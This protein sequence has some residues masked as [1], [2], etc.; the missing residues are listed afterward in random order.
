MQRCT[1]RPVGVT[2]CRRQFFGIQT[3][4]PRVGVEALPVSRIDCPRHDLNLLVVI[5][6]G[7]KRHR[8]VRQAL[9]LN[10]LRITRESGSVGCNLGPKRDADEPIEGAGEKQPLHECSLG[11]NDTGMHGKR[12]SSRHASRTRRQRRGSGEFLKAVWIDFIRSWLKRRVQNRY[13]PP[14]D[15]SRHVEGA[16]SCAESGIFH[17]PR[18]GCI[19][20]RAVGPFDPG[21]Y[22][23]LVGPGRDGAA[24][25]REFFRPAHRVPRLP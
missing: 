18:V 5:I 6:L 17:D 22:D 16:V 20:S 8:R 19:A 21:E 13:E 11:K 14:L 10:G 3:E 2:T 12:A 1:G 25:V 24:E 4:F 23:G 15:H 7:Q 9:L